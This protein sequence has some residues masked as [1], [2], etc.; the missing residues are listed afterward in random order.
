MGTSWDP[1]RESPERG[2]AGEGGQVGGLSQQEQSWPPP[3]P[4]GEGRQVENRPGVISK[5]N[6]SQ[7]QGISQVE[8]LV[9]SDLRLGDL[10]PRWAG[11]RK[12]V[13]PNG[14]PTRHHA[15]TVTVP[16]KLT[17]PT[18]DCIFPLCWYSHLLSMGLGG[19]VPMSLNKPQ[20]DAM[21]P[22]LV[23]GFKARCSLSSPHPGC[24]R[25]TPER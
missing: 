14:S 19:R 5:S 8:G 23:G 24:L 6:R 15:R 7:V 2:R 11:R 4:Q 18:A 16:A 9:L 22:P 21:R 3:A 12:W 13:I 1:A 20:R 10:G 17:C 25:D